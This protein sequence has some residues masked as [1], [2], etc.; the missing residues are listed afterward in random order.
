[1]T[2]APDNASQPT[3][4]TPR[5]ESEERPFS[6]STAGVAWDECPQAAALAERAGLTTEQATAFLHF[7]VRRESAASYYRSAQQRGIPKQHARA[8]AEAAGRALQQAHRVNDRYREWIKSLLDC[9]RNSKHSG[10]GHLLGGQMV[11]IDPAE[12]ATRERQ[13]RMRDRR[14]RKQRAATDPYAAPA[15][16]HDP[17]DY[18]VRGFRGPLVGVEDVRN[19]RLLA[20]PVMVMQELVHAGA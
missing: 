14:E 6:A 18:T 5:L 13:A 17:K 7:G 12:V 19:A 20:D 9:V 3:R 16:P 10:G 11:G 1:M 8:T 4:P 2:I 15:N